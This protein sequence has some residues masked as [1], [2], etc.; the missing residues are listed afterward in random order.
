M[1]HYSPL[2]RPPTQSQNAKA[3][4]G[5]IPN[6]STSCTI[7]ERKIVKYTTI[8]TNRRCALH[9]FFSLLKKK[10]DKFKK[11]TKEII[12]LRT[13]PFCNMSL[14]AIYYSIIMLVPFGIGT[15]NND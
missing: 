3:L 13:S 14:L 2:Y 6:C 8:I 4:L 5:S 9:D 11:N 15:S 7:N 12:T 10:M 1:K